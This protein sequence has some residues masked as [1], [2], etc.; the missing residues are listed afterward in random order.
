MHLAPFL[1]SNCFFKFNLKFKFQI[2]KKFEK[3]FSNSI[4]SSKVEVSLT[5]VS[6]SSS[7][8]VGFLSHRPVSFVGALFRM[9]KITYVIFCFIS[10]ARMQAS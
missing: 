10:Q 2:S 4:I 6:K 8:S 1:N 7:H 3:L 9:Y 5:S